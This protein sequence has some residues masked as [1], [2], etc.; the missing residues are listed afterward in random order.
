MSFIKTS[1]VHNN[2]PFHIKRSIIHWRGKTALN[3]DKSFERFTNM[4]YGLRAGFLLLRNCY[5]FSGL[6]TVPQIID[7]FASSLDKDVD[8]Y[9]KFIYANSPLFPNTQIMLQ[10]L[11]FY[12]LCKCICKYETDYDLSYN[13]YRQVIN[14]FHL[15]F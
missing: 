6:T 4:D 15:G 2:N 10:S 8:L 3:Y 1:C 7:K 11:S 12:H 9:C 13:R 14:K 5:L